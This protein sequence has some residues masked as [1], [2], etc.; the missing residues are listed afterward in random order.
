MAAQHTVSQLIC[1]HRRGDSRATDE[2]FAL[3]YK[4]LKV[5]AQRQ[6]A[7]RRLH[8]TVN[9]TALV[10]EAYLKLADSDH[11]SWEDQAH[12]K[13]VA[14]MAMRQ[15]L[16]DYARKQQAAKRGGQAHHTRLKASILFEH[17]ATVE[18]LDLD[19]A[20]TRLAASDARLSQ[21][22]EML[23]FGHLSTREVAEVLGIS[24]RTVRRDWFKARSYLYVA[25]RG[26]EET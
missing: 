20:L 2:L 10:H 24:P 8:Q 11:T 22:V 19:K 25:L 16:V 5:I 4:E 15:V 13:A 12:F 18:L 1:A 14:V 7:H 9:T 3:I 17:N 21:I 26:Q 23:F 6:L